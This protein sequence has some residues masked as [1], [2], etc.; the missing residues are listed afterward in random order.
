VTT[1]IRLTILSLLGGRKDN[2]EKSAKP[3]FNSGGL[4]IR[5]YWCICLSG[6][7]WRIQGCWQM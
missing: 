5:D 4:K 7:S 3:K 1:V 6:A 2:F